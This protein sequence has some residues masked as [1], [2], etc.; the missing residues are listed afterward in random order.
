MLE[1]AGTGRGNK[2]IRTGPSHYASEKRRPN[3]VEP[4]NMIC[5]KSGTERNRTEP[6][7]SCSTRE[8]TR[9]PLLNGQCAPEDRV[10]LVV[11][12]ALHFNTIRTPPGWFVHVVSFLP[13]INIKFARAVSCSGKKWSTRIFVTA[14]EQP[15]V[16]RLTTAQRVRTAFDGRLHFA[17]VA[18]WESESASP[19]HEKRPRPKKINGGCS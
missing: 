15:R 12:A 6:V 9:D 3:R 14:Y 16:R 17:A 8:A 7:P 5:E 10:N 1:P 11:V 2:P 4:G 19:Q 18:S 13:N